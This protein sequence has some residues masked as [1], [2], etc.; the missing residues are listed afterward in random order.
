[1]H[2]IELG[3]DTDSEGLIRVAMDDA[4]ETRV[5]TARTEPATRPP[6]WRTALPWVAGILLATIAGL[7]GWGPK[8]S[9]P[10]RL[11]GYAL[12]THTNG[13]TTPWMSQLAVSRTDT[14]VID[15]SEDDQL[16]V[17]RLDQLEA[18]PLRRIADI[19]PFFSSD[20]RSVGFR[21]WGFVDDKHYRGDVEGGVPG[22]ISEWK[23]GIEGAS[24]GPDDRLR[25]AAAPVLTTT[26]YRLTVSTAGSGGGTVTS[27]PP[28]IECPG[29]CQ[30]DFVEGTSVILIGLAD[31]GSA[32]AGFSGDEPCIGGSLMMLGD[33]NCIATFDQG[34]T[35][36]PREAA[37][38]AAGASV[39]SVSR[40]VARELIKTSGG[41]LRRCTV[42][43]L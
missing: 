7:A 42:A 40:L 12:G 17:R 18:V 29:D 1:M 26:L 16:H 8:P 28:G 32:F 38:T 25:T 22:G 39:P 34:P 5:L 9:S 11:A 36:P 37:E 2:V 13:P 20:G 31:S 3:G 4:F 35:G 21:R 24:W 41:P 27:S 23:N 6:G 19:N 15:S 14:A 43:R 10:R 33:R 30:E